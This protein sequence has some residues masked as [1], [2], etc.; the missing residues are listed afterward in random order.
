MKIIFKE[1]LVVVITDLDE[2]S[3][4]MTYA[5]ERAGTY[6]MKTELE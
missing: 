3:E 2:I 5:G 1:A 6:K 4:Q